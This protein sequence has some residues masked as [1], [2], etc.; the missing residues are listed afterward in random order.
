MT[1]DTEG[2]EGMG[3]DVIPIGGHAAPIKEVDTIR[4]QCEARRDEEAEKFGKSDGG[5][6][7]VSSSFVRDC[8]KMNE[9]GDGL[10]FCE[11]H[12]GTFVFNKAMDSWMVWSGHHWDVDTM[13]LVKSSVENVVSKYLREA[14]RV[15][16]EIRELDGGDPGKERSLASLR[17]ELNK[18]VTALRS[19]RRRSNCLGFAHTC[20]GALA[21]HGDEIDRKPWLLACK[22]SVIDLRT[23]KS[24][25]GRPGDYLM[26]HAAVEWQGIDAPC[27]EWERFLAQV[28][29]EDQLDAE[30]GRP[31]CEF[32]QRLLGHAVV[33]EQ[34]EH[35]FAVF[36]GIGRNGKGVIQ[37]I[38]IHVLGRLAGPVRS[39]ML[40]DQSRN[41]SA[42]APTPEIMALR[43][44]RV[45]FA[46]ETDEGCRVSA[47]R[48]KWMTGA[49]E[50]TG[51]SPHD[52]YEVT[53]TPTHSL[54]LMTNHKPS[55]PADDFAFWQ[56][57]LLVPF[58][59]S[60]VRRQPRCD[61]E[62]KADPDL[63]AR[64]M[65]EA[66][67]ILAWLV[68]GCLQW[69]Q[70]GLRPPPKVLEANQQYQADEDNVGAFIDYCCIVDQDNDSLFTGATALHEAFEVWWKKFVSN[71]PMK[72]K[73]FGQAMR[74]RFR[75]E[76][77][78]GVYRYYGIG[79]IDTVQ[80]PP[81]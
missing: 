37:R 15:S 54:F 28:M 18:R 6:D 52:K 38:M 63:E 80:D 5:G 71:F 59:L 2:K 50:L 45:A 27:Q 73:K 30:E 33:G 20:D 22:N 23:G 49:D 40:L 65:D 16:A 70:I 9:L 25:D 76:K 79:L 10:L 46:S 48:V 77:V 21:I 64:L 81:G 36:E 14:I 58:R 12:R 4:E 60:F 42:S 17:S 32:L 78:G 67:G 43:G 61:N 75:S 57:M 51:R 44:L 8:L 55:A 66:P 39:E 35:V 68:R 29:E 7:D 62:R 34:V 26:K 56:R 3:A 72:Q 13:D 53:W 19:T 41:T 24:R 11:L 1:D 69:Q 31:M 47:G 74:K